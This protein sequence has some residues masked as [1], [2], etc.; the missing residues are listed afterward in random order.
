MVE[1]LLDSSEYSLTG[2]TLTIT[3]ALEN[4]VFYVQMSR[5]EPLAP[6]MSVNV[7]NNDQVTLDSADGKY[8][9]IGF[10]TT[11]GVPTVTATE[12]V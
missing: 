1:Y 8:Y 3:G 7:I 5:S 6:E 2:T 11:N 4:E 9:Q 12:V 10:T